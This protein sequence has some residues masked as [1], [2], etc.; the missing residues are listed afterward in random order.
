MRV[1]DINIVEKTVLRL[2]NED[3]SQS[4]I[5][6]MLGFDIGCV[7]AELAS[8]GLLYPDGSFKD[9]ARQYLGLEQGF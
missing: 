6:D 8:K 3:Y 9:A 5:S 1:F 4:D 2:L 7:I